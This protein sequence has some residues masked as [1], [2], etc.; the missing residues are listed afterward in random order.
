MA[1]TLMVLVAWAQDQSIDN[2]HI[3]PRQDARFS[4]YVPAG[5]DASALRPRPMRVD[6]NLVLVPVTVV[7]ANIGR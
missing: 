6:V 5:R 3:A 4:S 7:D 1:A 2:P